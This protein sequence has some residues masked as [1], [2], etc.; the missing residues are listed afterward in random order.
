MKRSEVKKIVEKVFHKFESAG[1]KE[2]HKR[3]AD[4]YTG[5]SKRQNLKCALAN[6]IIRKFSVY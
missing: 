5:L 1:Y 6:E 3:T 2:L 4:G